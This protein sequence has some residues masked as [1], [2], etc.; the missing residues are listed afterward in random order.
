M[1]YDKRMLVH[2]ARLGPWMLWNINLNISVG[3][4]FPIAS[5][6]TGNRLVHYATGPIAMMFRL[7]VAGKSY[8]GSILA[9]LTVQLVAVDV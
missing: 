4:H 1:L 8:P 7:T 2:P 9:T 3:R 5:V 6:P